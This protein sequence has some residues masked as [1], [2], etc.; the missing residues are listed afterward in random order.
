MSEWVSVEERLPPEGLA[1][2]VRRNE[3]NWLCDHKLADG[4]EMKVWRW[5]TCR[6]RYGKTA[7]ELEAM[8][9]MVI[10]GEDQHGNNLVP[11]SWDT[12]GSGDLFG[13]SVSHWMAIE[14]PEGVGLDKE[15]VPTEQEKALDRKFRE[16]MEQAMLELVL[17]AGT[18]GD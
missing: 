6:I 10:R 17:K 13:Q 14:K 9:R 4:S 16:S 1:V 15:R 5:V 8:D 7:S 2:L 11:Y 18:K 12:F 3:D